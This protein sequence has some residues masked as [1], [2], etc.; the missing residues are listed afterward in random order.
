MSLPPDK[1]T[2]LKQIIHN[3][4]S[5]FDIQSSIRNVLTEI[6]QEQNEGQQITERELLSALNQKGVL[7]E[8][9]SRLQFQ[10]TGGA[11]SLTNVPGLAGKPATH[12]INKDEKL[13][14]APSVKKANLDPTRRYL[15][16]Q[17]VGGRAFLEHINEPESLPGQTCSALTIH[18]NFRGQRFR[19]RDVPIACEP[20][21]QESFLLE[22]H[23]DAAGAAAKMAD[24][25]TMLSI[26]DL[27]HVAIIK[28]EPS[29]ETS[30]VSSH[31]L[32]WRTVL[33]APSSRC[34]IAVELMGIGSESKVPVGVLETK[35]EIIP[36]TLDSLTEEILS[37][38]LQMEKAKK[39]ERER[40]FLIYAKQWWKEYLQIRPSHNERLIKIFATDEN[41]TNRPVCSYVRPLRAGRLI[42]TP[43]QAAR[44]TSLI[45]YEKT[46]IVG[47][48]N[49]LEQWSSMHAFL[50]RN[51]GDCEDHAVLLCCLLLGFGLDAYICI[52]TKSKGSVHTWLMTIDNDGVVTF[53]ESLTGHRYTHHPVNP[54][55]P[56]FDAQPKPSYPYKTIGCVFNNVA[57]FANSQPSDLVE[58]CVF[59]LHDESRWK[60]M[61]EDA[62][63]SV[64][65]PTSGC[66]WSYLPPL[67]PS[68]L[69]SSLIANDL[70][71]QLRVLV[72]E[73]RRDQGLT[74]V[75]DDHLSYL[76]TPALSS[77][78]M[79][80]LTGV[81]AGNEEFQ[82]AIRRCVPDGHTFKGYP[83][84][85]VHRNARRAFY[86]CLRSPICD[87]IINCRGDL[88]RLA[89][90][91]RVYT[92]PESVCATWIMFAC[93]YK[94]V[95]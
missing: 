94:C 80:R 95:L 90:R 61:S 49:R 48:G 74:T 25:T 68:L 45:G 65:D 67:R 81:S 77:Y 82:Q 7:D 93:K 30:L 24:N 91:V 86:G 50:C 43:R 52:G 84:Q 39:A 92:Y 10:S 6:L 12:F 72:T 8:I 58:L 3:H 14:S 29:G 76:L 44:F 70:E 54:D 78:E 36:K 88:L 41:G 1:I 71:Q 47:G 21:F 2:E 15:Y 37:A 38:Q 57:F 33:A 87:E 5:Q 63:R 22:L 23:K 27:V 40:L 11:T 42:D 26:C 69:D 4:L 32:D 79:E 60:S 13:L 46:S 85:F 20:D 18:V 17:F 16:L 66:G 53:W 9:M 35:L 55:D 59:E 89:L 34:S 56:P 31:Y 19:S 83:I 28:T 75:W 73:H 51:K 62:V 64:S